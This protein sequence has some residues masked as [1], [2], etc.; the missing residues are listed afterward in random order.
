[1]AIRDRESPVL[2]AF[3]SRPRAFRWCTVVAALFACARPALG[4]EVC[5]KPAKAPLKPPPK[6]AVLPTVV[7]PLAPA[8]GV[9]IPAPTEPV[10][11]TPR[12]SFDA[13]QRPVGLVVG[14]AG[15]VGLGVAGAFTL[16]MLTKRADAQ[17]AC[18]PAPCRQQDRTMDEARASG[19]IAVLAA[20]SGF[21]LAGAGAVL[22]LTAP[23][24]PVVHDLRFSP[25]FASGG[26]GI[27]AKASF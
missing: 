19:N 17:R 14:G 26:G 12:P 18:S 16:D 11:D 20:V 9:A 23:A 7:V 1:M 27:S 6:P 22:Y 3:G 10:E 8:N 21:A 5:E 24:P 13:W 2:K 4:D 15:V 25:T